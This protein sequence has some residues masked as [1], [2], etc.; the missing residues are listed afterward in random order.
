MKQKQVNKTL[1]VSE[2]RLV[3]LTIFSPELEQIS[4]GEGDVFRE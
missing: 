4:T 1:L 3:W 2:Q